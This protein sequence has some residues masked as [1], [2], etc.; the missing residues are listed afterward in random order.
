[1]GLHGYRLLPSRASCVHEGSS[2]THLRRNMA[3]NCNLASYYLV[4]FQL[5]FLIIQTVLPPL[6]LMVIRF[7][8]LKVCLPSAPALLWTCWWEPLILAQPDKASLCLSEWRPCLT[9]A[10]ERPEKLLC[11]WSNPCDCW[12]DSMPL[13]V[14]FGP[15]CPQDPDCVSRLCWWKAPLQSPC[16]VSGTNE[17]LI[18]GKCVGESPFF[19]KNCRDV[20][21]N[22]IPL[23][24][25]LA[26]QS[27][28]PMCIF[29]WLGR[30]TGLF[31]WVYFDLNC[32]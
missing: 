6:K 9:A 4:Q 32:W 26:S 30:S 19:S 15:L 14:R 7:R 10:G 22:K 17:A 1:M 3:P 28:I 13:R 12:T 21:V 27:N 5:K 2:C 16:E 23:L 31:F 11:A 25:N 29:V 8:A 24:A 20:S 18:Q